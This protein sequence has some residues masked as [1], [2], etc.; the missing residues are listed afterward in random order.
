MGRPHLDGLLGFG[1]DP[2]VRR[3]AA[4]EY[5]DVLAL[6]VD[7]GEFEVALER[8]GCNWLPHPVC[9]DTAAQPAP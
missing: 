4:G 5:E 8:R 7:D 2:S 6:A 9:M 3:A 1:V